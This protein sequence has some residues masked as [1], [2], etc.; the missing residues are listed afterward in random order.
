MRHDYALLMHGWHGLL[1]LR[2]LGLQLQETVGTPDHEG[3][4]RNGYVDRVV[5]RKTV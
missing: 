1:K 2:T 4:G 5:S 3:E